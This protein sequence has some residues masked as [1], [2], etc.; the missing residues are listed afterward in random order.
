MLERMHPVQALKKMIELGQQNLID[1]TPTAQGYC[2]R[3]V[4]G[5]AVHS[6]EVV[7]INYDFALAPT[8]AAVDYFYPSGL[9]EEAVKQSGLPRYL[10]RSWMVRNLYEYGNSIDNLAEASGYHPDLLGQ[11]K[12]GHGI[13]NALNEYI[14]LLWGGGKFRRQGDLAKHL[15][16]S[17]A[18]VSNVVG[19]IRSQDTE[20]M[21]RKW[22]LEGRDTPEII[23]LLRE[24]G[25]RRNEN[26]LKHLIRKMRE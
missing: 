18:T 6:I 11:A 23:A 22:L 25:D 16:V 17:L 2:A 24:K 19:K 14:R 4:Y 7:I 5:D 8:P 10:S 26:K 3:F 20:G 9:N 12:R 13:E 1:I 21:V 15:N